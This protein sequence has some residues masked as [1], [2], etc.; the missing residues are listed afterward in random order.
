MSLPVD[1]SPTTSIQSVRS[2]PSRLCTHLSCGLTVLHGGI[3]KLA[4]DE[5]LGVE[6]LHRK[7]HQQKQQ[8]SG[9]SISVAE[10]RGLSPHSPLNELS[11]FR[12]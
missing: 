7:M 6:H 11:Q 3:R 2:L 4:T 12:L 1:G 8:G 5:A 9:G 10:A